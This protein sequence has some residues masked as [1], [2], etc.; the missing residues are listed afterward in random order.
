MRL[1]GRLDSAA[2]ASA[3]ALDLHT[4]VLGPHEVET[5]RSLDA[6]GLVYPFQGRLPA[7][8]T[9]SRDVLE[10]R[11]RELGEEHLDTLVARMHLVGVLMP[12]GL[13]SAAAHQLALVRDGCGGSTRHTRSSRGGVGRKCPRTRT[14]TGSTRSG[15]ITI[16]RGAPDFGR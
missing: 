13:P 6:L 7:A 2:R 8:E 11:I 15:S 10:R 4:E 16:R 3:A 12:R 9:I 14:W 1:G 5:M